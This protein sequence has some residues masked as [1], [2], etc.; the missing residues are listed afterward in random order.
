[1]RERTGEGQ[2]VDT[3]MLG[4]QVALLTYQAGIF[5]ATGE[6]PQ[7]TGNAHPIVAPYQTFPTADGFVNIAVGNDRLWAA[8][9]SAMGMEDIAADE[10]FWDNSGRITNLPALAEII[11]GVF[12]GY[13]TDEIVGRLDAAG[14]PSGPIYSVPEVFAD[15]QVQHAGLERRVDHPT[16]GEISVTGFPY[17][18]S[19]TD[20]A[21][22]M[23][24]PLL[25]EHQAEVLRELGY[26]EEEI[27]AGDRG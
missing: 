13:T 22:R 3:S 12:A 7:P 21:L 27:A 5:F 19:E 4:G 24:P 1:Y 9:T 26:S 16:L 23:P 20:A 18:L 11:E 6:A 15:P 14:V 2:F 8:F 25:G 10:R 17:T